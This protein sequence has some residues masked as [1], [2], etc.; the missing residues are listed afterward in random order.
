[1]TKPQK[2]TI[3]IAEIEGEDLVLFINS[4]FTCTG[5][6]EFY[7]I[8]EQQCLSINFLHQYILGNYRRLYALTLATGIN[9]FNQALI[10]FNLLA[11]G[12]P[13]DVRHKQ[14]E[15]DLIKICLGR[16][17]AN[18][19]F[20][21][22]HNLKKKRINNRRT[23]AVIKCFLESR[24]DPDFDAVKYRSKIKQVVLHSHI[25]LTDERSRFLFEKLTQGLKAFDTPI[26]DSYQRAKYSKK[27]IYELPYT[28]AESFA[29][30][31]GIARDVFL[32]GI[33]AKLTKNE[34][35]RLQK[36]ADRERN[37]SLEVDFNSI[38][39]TRLVLYW[40]SLSYEKQKLLQ[41]DF[42]VALSH[43]AK[44]IIQNSAIT[45]DKI[46][47]V[48]DRS[49]SM[50]GSI[51]KKR[52]P[53]AIGFALHQILQRTVKNYKVFWSTPV[54]R[55]LHLYPKG[56]SNIADPFIKA[57]KMEPDVLLILSDGFENDP[58]GLTAQIHHA[59]LGLKQTSN[60]NIIHLNP[61]YDANSFN[62]KKLA[63]TITTVGIRNAEDITV[64]L[65]Y[66]RFSNGRASIDL[67]EAFVYKKYIEEKNSAN[68]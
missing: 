5:Q 68:R 65:E 38:D 19:V 39:L 49:F 54:T 37:I 20:K 61:V 56:Q 16:L 10:V 43:H 12:S 29:Q 33:E 4:C 58:A 57:L 6:K 46:A 13:K 25:K 44:N 32:K 23:R 64:I 67:L 14:E 60:T 22:F 48:V 35:L 42:E 41:N 7:D 50:W 24:H 9:H 26:F 31:H 27:A 55:P 18:R 62:V 21:L 40:L 52:R 59:W 28:V 63:N 30:R 45:E 66:C 3:N 36:S 51:E 2:R 34:K 47:L 1:M 53:L 15:S 8:D 17:P 11:A